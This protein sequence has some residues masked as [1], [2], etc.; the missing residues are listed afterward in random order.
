V[1]AVKDGSMGGGVRLSG[2]SEGD[3]QEKKAGRKEKR[4]HGG[5]G[6]YLERSSGDNREWRNVN[7]GMEEGT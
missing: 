7:G 4:I 6:V 1:T 2:A 5:A 3:D